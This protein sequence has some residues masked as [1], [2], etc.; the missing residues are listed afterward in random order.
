MP[1]NLAQNAHQLEYTRAMK[2]RE[3][4]SDNREVDSQDLAGFKMTSLLLRFS[5]TRPNLDE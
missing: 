2:S 4:Q 1:S 5:N 3:L